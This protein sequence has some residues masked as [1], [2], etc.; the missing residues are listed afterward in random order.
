[1]KN[2]NFKNTL[3]IS[4][5]V[6]V[7]LLLFLT[8]SLLML[9]R[10][11]VSEQERR[12]LAKFPE[13]TFESYIDGSFMR[14]LTAWFAD[15]VP[16]RDNI[17]ELSAFIGNLRGVRVDNVTFHGNVEQVA[18]TTT[19]PVTTTAV[20]T[21][22]PETP[23]LPGVITTAPPA[24]IITETTPVTTE[25]TGDVEFDSNGIVTIGDRGVMLF[26]GNKGEGLHYA[27]V[28]NAYKEA[29]GEAVN[30]YAM[31]VPTAVEFYLPKKY[32]EYSNPEKPQIDWIYENL[33]G[34][35]GVDAYTEIAAHTSEDIYLKTD[36]HWSQLGAYYASVAFAKA[37]G[38]TPQS[39]E[40][41]ERLEREGFVGSLYGYTNDINLKNNPEVF[42]YYKQNLPYK[43][44]A[45]DCKTLEP[46][47]ETVL[48]HEYATLENSY[49]M[50]IGKDALH[51]RIVTE[52][53]N[54]KKLCVFKDSFGNALIP[55]LIPY[56]EEIYVIDIRF[57]GMSA[58][59]YMKNEGITDILF[60]DN[61]F[62]ANTYALINGL[63][64][65]LTKGYTLS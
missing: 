46:L 1:M 27:N 16:F 43:T 35:I 49:G 10:P 28:M 59:E 65:M 3:L 42:T 29:M 32:S 41:Y 24:E 34:V 60:L 18:I 54:G 7:G 44:Y 19:T 25:A 21:T 17:V 36:H 9:P 50:F 14:D 5:L 22:V 39:I 62:A 23:L 64:T 52:N 31:T 12:D 8:L 38:E 6:L 13:F 61:I 53:T 33:N 47:G 30:V 57:F 56:F 40:D 4:L 48:Y 37:L 55:E 63:E 26:G 2:K 20:T 51:I 11:T 15:T 58:T 45:Y